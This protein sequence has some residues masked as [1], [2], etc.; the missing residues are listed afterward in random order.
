MD[1]RAL[2]KL[3]RNDLEGSSG[4]ERSKMRWINDVQSDLKALE[5]TN[6][7]TVA[8]NRAE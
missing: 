5:V 1:Q 2:V 4:V 3:F 8:Q 7:R 6:W